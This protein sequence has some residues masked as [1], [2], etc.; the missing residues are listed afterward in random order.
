MRDQYLDEIVER[1]EGRFPQFDHSTMQMVAALSNTYHILLAVMER[2][3]SHYGITPQAMDVLIALYV[4][5]ESGGCLLGELADLLMVTP[6][7]ITGLVQGLVK[8]GLVT[9]KELA[10]DRR[11]RLAQ[12]TP[13]GVEIIEDIIPASAHFFHEAFAPVSIEDKQRLFKGLRQIS[14]LLMPYWD[15]RLSP[16]FGQPDSEANQDSESA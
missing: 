11:K 8:K 2:A 13:H 4:K 3:V 16:R 1:F 10:T 5:Q 12:I 6:A 9:R 15:K 14:S 7:N